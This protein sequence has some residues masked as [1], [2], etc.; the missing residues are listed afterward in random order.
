MGALVLTLL[1]YEIHS[2]CFR[3]YVSGDPVICKIVLFFFPLYRPR[4]GIVRRT[5]SN[6]YKI[7]C[8]QF[9]RYSMVTS[10]ATRVPWVSPIELPRDFKREIP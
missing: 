10:V 1:I 9:L 8:C 6:T 7:M 2:K 3:D 5:T 4:S